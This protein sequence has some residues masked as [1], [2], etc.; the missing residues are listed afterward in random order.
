MATGPLAW[1]SMSLHTVLVIAES[2][3]GNTK[4]VADAIA[5]GIQ[6][7]APKARVTTAL[8]NEAP[9]IAD[10]LDLL[11]LGGPTHGMSMSRPVTRSDAQQRGAQIAGEQ[12]IRE[13]IAASSPNRHTRVVV[14]DTRV[15]WFPGSAARSASAELKKTG[16]NVGQSASFFLRG[17]TGP[18]PEQ[19][20]E[21]AREWGA[22]L[23]SGT[24]SEVP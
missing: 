17:Y 19:Q 12:G 9:A 3:W 11:V 15:R 24:P 23:A 22:S 21:R 14:F 18:I 7:V 6:G 20:L 2:H 5:K 8:V 13:W 4:A 16:W 1:P 10:D